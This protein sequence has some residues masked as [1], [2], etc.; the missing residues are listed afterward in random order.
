MVARPISMST[1][2]PAV[3]LTVSAVYPGA[4]SDSAAAAEAELLEPAA[5]QAPGLPA[6]P[7][8]MGYEVGEY[9]TVAVVPVF[10]DEPGIHS[11]EI[12]TSIVYSDA[13]P[14][15]H[16]AAGDG[17]DFTTDWY[18]ADWS[19][20][21]SLRYLSPLSDPCS[22]HDWI[23]EE[24]PT[25]DRVGFASND[26]CTVGWY[27]SEL[28]SALY[29][30]IEASW[31]PRGWLDGGLTFTLGVNNLLEKQ[32]RVCYPCGPDA[33]TGDADPAARGQ[34]YYARIRLQQ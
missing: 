23:S 12:R 19:A 34:Y 16:S 28:N 1:I 6:L 20:R 9:Y 8:P 31:A 15:H 25:L 27:A 18:L 3:L 32:P 26:L 10:E 13:G 17:I 30:D 5:P 33:L 4:F 7:A 24:G 22:G 11:L 14:G 21:L 29:T 2:A